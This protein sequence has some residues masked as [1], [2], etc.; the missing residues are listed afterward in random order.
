VITS[1]YVNRNWDGSTS[2]AAAPHPP[3]KKCP[4]YVFLVP[5]KS[6][7][8]STLMRQSFG[9]QEFSILSSLGESYVII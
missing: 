2:A 5:C 6:M 4:A 1:Q 8:K 7:R 9:L 3:L